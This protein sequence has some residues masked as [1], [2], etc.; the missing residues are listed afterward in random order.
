MTR[1]RVA[2]CVV[3][4][5]VLAIGC[6]ASPPQDAGAAPQAAAPAEAPNPAS[7]TP[8]GSAAIQGAIRFDGTA[9]AREKIQMAADPTCQQQ[10]AAPVL[11]EAVVVNDNGTLKHA[12][13][14]VKSGLSGSFAPPSRPAVMDQ[15]GCWY[16]PHVLG[17]QA[18]QPVELRNSDA[19]LHNVN[20]KPSQ[21]PPFNLAQP[22][23]GMKTTKKFAKP[24]IMVPLKCNVHPWMSAYIGVV[25]HPFFAVSDASGAYA[26]SGLPAGTYVV[27]AWHEKLGT[28]T[29]SVTVA[30]GQTQS[31][32]FT[33]KAQ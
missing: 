18:N 10:H 22:V 28:Q 16:E 6:G 3:A 26:L 29:Q 25:E 14:Y 23:Q 2:S 4:G 7:A 30:D 27:E 11:S 32:D 13:V 15:H 9:P 21:N 20:A 31:V 24:E 12:F 17:V 1:A 19:T 5:M 8:A 33:F